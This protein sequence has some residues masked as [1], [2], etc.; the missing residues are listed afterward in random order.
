MFGGLKSPLIS[1]GEA[2]I[3]VSFEPLEALRALVK[4]H[5]DST[6]ITN[7]KPIIP[8]TVD[9]GGP[10][11]PDVEQC[12]EKMKEQFKK[13]IAVD[14]ESIA[15]H[16]GTSKAVNVVLLGVLLGTGLVDVAPQSME[17]TIKMKVKPKFVQANLDAFHQGLEQGRNA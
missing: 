1:D 8:F 6:I 5:K 12:V 16:A 11:Y 17:E 7:T 14:A 13:V 2:D 9:L 10:A 4:C 15:K 3:L